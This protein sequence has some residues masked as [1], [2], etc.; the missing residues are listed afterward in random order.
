[1]QNEDNPGN[2]GEKMPRALNPFREKGNIQISHN[3]K[4]MV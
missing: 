4:E 3:A 1:M 2:V